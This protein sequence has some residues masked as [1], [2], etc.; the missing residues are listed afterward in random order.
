MSHVLIVSNRLPVSVSKVDGKLVFSTSIGGLATGLQ[1]YAKNRRST[2]VGWPGIPSDELTAADK[3]FI[4]K[5]LAKSKCTPVF[6]SQ[7]Q[8]DEFYN[9]YS[10]DLLWPLFHSLK[11]KDSPHHARWWKAYREVNQ[12]FADAAKKAAQPGSTIWV[13]DYQL[14]LVPEYIRAKKPRAN[15]GFFVHIPFPPAKE[16]LGFPESKKLV[17]GLLNADLLGFHTPNYVADFLD[18]CREL[19]LGDAEDGQVIVGSRSVRVTDFPM[20]IDYKRFAAA[21]KLP[22]VKKAVRIYK[23]RYRRKKII[24]AVDRLDISKGFVERLNAYREYLAHHPKMHGKVVFVLVGAPSRTDIPAYQRLASRVER[25]AADINSMYGNS[26]WQPVDYINHAI[27]FEQVT[28]L[29]QV[30]DVA[31]IAPLKDGMNLV[32]KE[33]IASKHG[34]GVLILSDTAGAAQELHDAIVVNHREPASLVNALEQALS[35]P[36]REV[37]ARLKRMQQHLSEHTVQV[38]AGDFMTTLKKPIPTIRRSVTRKLTPVIATKMTADFRVA[39]KRALF[40][41]YDGTLAPIVTR[42]EDAIPTTAL[43][44]TLKKLGDHKDT[45]VHVISGRSRNDLGKWLGDLPVTLIAEHGAFERHAGNKHWRANGTAGN[46]WKQDVK[47][48]LQRY[49]DRTPGA[50]VEEKSTALVWHYREASAYTAQKHLVVIKR[51]LQPLLRA[52]SLEA[53]DGKMILEIKHRDTSKGT[54]VA[55][56]LSAEQYNFIMTIGDDYTD[57]SM[58]KVMP[59][60]AYSIKVGTGKSA[61][62][63]RVKDTDEVFRLLKSLL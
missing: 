37:R 54:Q 45:D 24:A 13:H 50:H 22:E 27:P 60:S 40:L 20:G 33:F 46:D 48:I 53:H 9:G 4:I 17:R 14:L 62:K 38:W 2:W 61:A 34:E 63:I 16:F 18:I 28:A 44:K 25:L 42:P 32:A 47:P 8:V 12:L 23:Q 3:K 36:K 58:F 10:N 41:D 19:K 31:F 29:F 21:D 43:L 57:E 6:L 52:H 51:L 30:A 7:K 59:E 49:A 1:D 35:M 55:K 5:R 26:R 39:R 11:F 56:K 15:I